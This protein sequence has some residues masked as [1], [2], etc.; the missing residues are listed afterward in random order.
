MEH[1]KYIQTY[2]YLLDLGCPRNMAWLGTIFPEQ[3]CQ[4]CRC[5]LFV[6]HRMVVSLSSAVILEQS[7][8]ELCTLD[9]HQS[10]L[11]LTQPFWSMRFNRV[12]IKYNFTIVM[13]FVKRFKLPEC[14]Q[15][16]WCDF[17]LPSTIHQTAA[18][19]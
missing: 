9:T 2:Y 15:T 10:R 14:G 19:T 1:Y 13:P 17:Q 3:W 8:A 5:H 4:S 6:C 11:Q 12:R 16:V 7:T 18:A